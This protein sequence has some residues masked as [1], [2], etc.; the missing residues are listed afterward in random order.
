M[1]GYKLL[2]KTAA[3][4]WACVWA[5]LVPASCILDT[6]YDAAP[7]GGKILPRATG[8][9]TE[10]T[11]DWM[12]FNLR[13]GEVFNKTAPSQEIKEG[14]QYSRTDWDMAFCGYHIR[15]NSGTSGCGKG[16]AIDLGY[17]GY[18]NWTSV[19]QLPANAQWI[20]DNAETVHITVSQADWY[21]YLSQNGL[22]D[23]EYPWFDPNSGPQRT[24]TSANPL[25]EENMALSGPPR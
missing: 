17:G 12:Y 3:C 6:D 9:T 10:V 2:M 19:S 18:K 20:T 25:L 13:T 8:Y 4:V 7:F 23:A 5:C 21:R 16:G 15:T 24:L 22:S 11:N 14:E 1:K